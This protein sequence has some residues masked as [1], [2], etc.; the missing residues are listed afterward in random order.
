MKKLLVFILLLVNNLLFAC[1]FYPCGEDVRMNFLNN[2][3]F[4]CFTF[5]G[6]E[7]SSQYYYQPSITENESIFNAND[8]LWFNYCKKKVAISDVTDAVY[9]ITEVD[10]NVENSNK[11][12]QYL[13][14]N[15]DFI[16]INYLKFAKSCEVANMFYSDPWER[17]ENIKVNIIQKKINDALKFSN[18]TSNE[19]IKLRY[20]FLAIRLAFY[21][22]LHNDLI[23]IYS[24]IPK[25][26]NP[27]I[28]YYWCMHFRAMVESNKSLQSFYTAQVFANAQD[29]RF[30]IYS[31]FD[32]SLDINLILKYTKTNKEKANVYALAAT[33]KHDKALSFIKKSYQL[34]PKSDFNIFILLRE[35]NKIEDWVF[36][37]Y[38]T[39]FN[40]SIS[41][42]F[43]WNDDK[44]IS[45]KA[46]ENRIN[47][48]RKYA[49]EVLN[50]L[51]TIK[52]NDT[53]TQVCQAQLY[54]IA[55][56][57]N[58]SL[59][60]IESLENKISKKDSLH[61]DIQIIKALN[62]TAN[63]EK[64][65]AIISP[66]IKP[67]IIKNKKNK[68]FLF[69]VA[70]ELEYLGN[71]TDA[72]FLFSNI[73]YKN[74]EDNFE[75]AW[76]SR[77]HKRGSY[78]DYFYDY[79]GYVDIL[80]TSEQLEKIIKKVNSLEKDDDFNL[81]LKSRLII[82]KSRLYDLLGTKYIRKN[83]LKNALISFKK[84]DYK[85]WNDYYSL[86][87]VKSYG[88]NS[89]DKNPFFTF[90]GTP[91]F[92]KTKEDFLL[93]KVTFTEKLI[94]YI[95]KA[96]NPK[97]KSRDYYYFV[98]ANCYKNMTVNGNSW[99]M[100][101][102]SVSYYDVEPFPEDENEF[103]NG[104]LAKKYY[105]LAYKY[106]KS[107]KFKALCL[108]LAQDFKKLKNTQE[109]EYYELSNKSCY[110]FE[111]YFNSRN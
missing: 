8:N 83:D 54:F 110:A 48:D 37:P 31:Y 66:I 67:I 23:N 93:T 89:F 86:W 57:Y 17:V 87:N 69:A 84:T 106:S 63:Q 42:R 16:A 25:I 18:S 60:L 3:N 97:E 105:R 39:N 51:E 34:N 90:K 61:N 43:Y 88:R 5:N 12:I 49:N 72:A 91:E 11:M 32:K 92:I 10:F 20:K 53:Y 95:K 75:L 102:F 85:Y 59:K 7:Y 45:Y 111:D 71:T 64:N 35:V 46:I 2:A 36:T 40:P 30:P 99:M 79:F 19:Q 100:R 22:G 78:R 47:N 28:I 52:N 26:K 108:W 94:E 14:Q 1:G 33:K 27:S 76:K 107:K 70:R 82:E 13:L 73:N 80:Y 62:I 65:K 81:W 38:Y 24:T 103:Q 56:K 68:K 4:N 55:K 6:F 41:D 77:K 15:K 98:V 21:G 9:K 109:E 96:N 29:K 104:Y 50:F 58:K 44:I 101:R 74:N